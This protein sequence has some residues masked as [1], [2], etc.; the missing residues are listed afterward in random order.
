MGPSKAWKQPLVRVLMLRGHAPCH[1]RMCCPIIMKYWRLAPAVHCLAGPGRTSG[2]SPWGIWRMLPLRGLSNPVNERL[3]MSG[4][5]EKGSANAQVVGVVSPDLHPRQPTHLAARLR[6]AAP[7][8]P[9]A[10]Q[11]QALP[12]SQIA[13]CGKCGAE[14]GQRRDECNTKQMRTYALFRISWNVP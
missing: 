11:P 6:A 1:C 3:C 13:A 9:L 14:Y 10:T 5:S 12:V 8:V 2:P 7:S 4:P